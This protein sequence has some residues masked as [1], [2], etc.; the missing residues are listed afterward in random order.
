MCCCLH[1]Y[2]VLVFAHR[3]SRGR[4]NDITIT[5]ACC[6]RRLLPRDG[7][8][9]CIYHSGAMTNIA[10]PRLLDGNKIASEIKTEVQLGTAKLRERGIQPGLAAVLVGNNPASE[11]Y[12]RNKV[13]TC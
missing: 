5:T 6:R 4:N 11:I 7:R 9:R 3:A 2:S 1:T 8:M 12:V 10:P 13:R